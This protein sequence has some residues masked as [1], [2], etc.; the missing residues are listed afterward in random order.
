M[1]LNGLCPHIGLPREIIDCI[2]DHEVCSECVDDFYTTMKYD[3]IT[4]YN[5]LIVKELKLRAIVKIMRK[6]TICCII[7]IQKLEN[8]KNTPNYIL[9]FME[10]YEINNSIINKMTFDDLY[11]IAV[12]CYENDCVNYDNSDNVLEYACPVCMGIIIPD[13]E[14]INFLLVKYNL[15]IDDV[16]KEYIIKVD[17]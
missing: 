5:N 6:E 2:N 4:T 7:N 13:R 10:C 11:R 15:S 12:Y 3:N 14:I 1:E 9:K 16:R 17:N 8:D